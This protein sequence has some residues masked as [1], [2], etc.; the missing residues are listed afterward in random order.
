MRHS[1]FRTLAATLLSV[2]VSVF[3]AA[4]LEQQPPAQPPPAQAPQGR[5]Q[6]PQG[7][8]GQP[9]QG[10]GQPAQPPGNQ[11]AQQ[12][13]NQTP[14]APEP[15]K[16]KPLNTKF[17]TSKDGTKIAYDVTG[18]GPHLMLL[19][20]AGQSRR[21][22]HDLKYVDQL[23]VGSTVI[24]VDLRGHGESD[25]PNAQEAYAID[26]LVEDLTAVA[27]AAGAQRFN[28][29]GYAYGAHV[30]RYLVTR[31]DRVR[32]MVYIGVGFG[33]AIDGPT[34][35]AIEGLKAKW[36]HLIDAQRAAKVDP[37]SLADPY[38][39]AMEGGLPVMVAK[40]GALMEYPPVEPSE[41]KVPTLWLVGTD[42]PDAMAQIKAYDGKLGT[43]VTVKT[44][45]G[46]N[47]SME[48]YKVDAVL[49]VMLEFTVKQK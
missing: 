41:M 34:K 23:S 35:A 1:Y 27:D 10:R 25:K 17:V 11:T 37:K 24:T 19:H 22:W 42:N 46:L 7:R 18:T 5:G 13:G 31:T 30:G 29:W 40:M 12:P 2:G 48:F 21:D 26:R 39:S 43:N 14:P 6:E 38:R 8:G 9:P 28:L 16:P 33:P 4:A 32:S 44:L 20:G 49:P 3:A 47:H 36:K 45:D 15:P